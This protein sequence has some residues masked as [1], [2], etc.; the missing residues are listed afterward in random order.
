MLQCPEITLGGNLE[1]SIFWIPVIA[2]PIV[3]PQGDKRGDAWFKHILLSKW[4]KLIAVR[5][6][7]SFCNA[8]EWHPTAL[9]TVNSRQGILVP[10]KAF[11]LATCLLLVFHSV[12]T[13]ERSPLTF[14]V[15]GTLVLSDMSTSHLWAFS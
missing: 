2:D 8:L 14:P 10:Y 1:S 5:S 6:Y 15:P 12:L 3:V 11:Y 9:E 7:H 4:I 13:V